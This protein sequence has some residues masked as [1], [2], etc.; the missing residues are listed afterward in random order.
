MERNNREMK[1]LNT[2][3]GGGRGVHKVNRSTFERDR[4]CLVNEMRAQIFKLVMRL[5]GTFKKFRQRRFLPSNIRSQLRVEYEKSTNPL[6][7]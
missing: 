2:N 6:N 1:N 4:M 3:Q 5:E 7:E